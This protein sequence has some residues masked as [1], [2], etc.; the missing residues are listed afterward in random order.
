MQRTKRRDPNQNGSEATFRQSATMNVDVSSH[1]QHVKTR[2][3]SDEGILNGQRRK[4]QVSKERKTQV[5]DLQS[6][7]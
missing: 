1:T 3:G 7:P 4:R 5:E 6:L 2:Y